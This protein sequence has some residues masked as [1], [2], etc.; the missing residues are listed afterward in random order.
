MTS[1]SLLILVHIGSVLR[2]PQCLMVN[3]QLLSWWNWGFLP[4]SSS[5]VTECEW[6]E[7]GVVFLAS[8]ASLREDNSLPLKTRPS[9]ERR[10]QSGKLMTI[11]INHKWCD[12]TI[13]KCHSL[14]L[15]MWIEW[16]LAYWIMFH[17]F[18]S[19]DYRS[20]LILQLWK[21]CNRRKYFFH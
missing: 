10:K 14:W 9:K 4:N 5:G 15:T 11:F 16:W 12:S 20:L 3:H 13:N 8:Q 6:S 19:N 21:M 1:Q 7:H 17:L 18:S 2:T